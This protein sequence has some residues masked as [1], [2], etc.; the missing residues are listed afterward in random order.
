MLAGVVAIAVPISV[1]LAKLIAGVE[2]L[3]FSVK[4]ADRHC[5]VEFEVVSISFSTIIHL[6]HDPVNDKKT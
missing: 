6:V 1:R 5:F 2:W 4:L 3:D